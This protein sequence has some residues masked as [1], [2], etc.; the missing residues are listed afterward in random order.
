MGETTYSTFD[1]RLRAVHAVVDERL[2]V[3]TVSRAYGTDRCTIHRWVSRFR[4]EG[5]PGLLRRPVSGRPRKVAKLDR[6]RLRSIVLA[7]A[8]KY[9]YETDFWTTRRLIQVIQSDFHVLLSKQTV[10][11]RLHEA[12]LTYQKPE[13]EYFELSEEERQEWVRTEVPKIRA[14]V[15]EYKAILYFQDEAHV[16]LTALL[17]R[18]WALCGQ[19]PKQKVTGKRGGVSAMSAI[20]S[21]GRLIFRLHDKRIA[22]QEVID[23]LA[24]MLKHHRQRHLVVV[25]DQAPP[26]VSK[27]TRAFI[28]SQ[29][30][31]HVFPLPKYSPDWNSDE[32]VWNHLKHQELK[33]HQA[34]TKTELQDLTHTKLTAMSRDHDLLQGIFFRCCVAELLS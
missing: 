3:S 32:K 33:G 11:R 17:G 4:Q 20:T 12:G 28:E 23:F 13:R 15:Q 24:Q 6:D 18:T 10:M 16:S 34:R 2:P 1:V 19:T 21:R 7:P 9:G 14:A 8:S 22:S 5:D 31:L 26:H 27:A 30:R 25:M 29:P